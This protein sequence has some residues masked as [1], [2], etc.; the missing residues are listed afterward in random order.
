MTNQKNTKLR[1]K[2]NEII[3][4]SGKIWIEDEIV[5]NR[6]LLEGGK[7]TLEM[8]KEDTEVFKKLVKKIKGK[9]LLL[10][11]VGATE[12]PKEVRNYQVA[13]GPKIFDKIATV[14]GNPVSRVIVSFYLGLTKMPIPMQIF[15]TVDEAI[16]W[17]KEG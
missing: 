2:T 15:G 9:K 13:E 17:L 5:R 10:V 3:T 4:K 1:D 14:G 7:F 6:V 12:I 16:R 11:E 8:A